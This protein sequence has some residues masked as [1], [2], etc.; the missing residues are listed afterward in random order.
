MP[1]SL[2]QMMRDTA[3]KEAGPGNIGAETLI[4]LN[5]E[6]LRGL[7]KKNIFTEE[8]VEEIFTKATEGATDDAGD[9]LRSIYEEYSDVGED[10]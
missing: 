5:I 7:V 6:L 4:A 8:E 9:W 10:R 1:K 3:Q 2:Y